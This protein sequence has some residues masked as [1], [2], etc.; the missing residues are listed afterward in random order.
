MAVDKRIQHQHLQVLFLEHLQIGGLR[1]LVVGVE[2]FLVVGFF[3]TFQIVGKRGVVLATRN[4]EDHAVLHLFVELVVAHHA[5]LDEG[6]DIFPNR[7][8]GFHV[9]GKLADFSGDPAGEHLADLA[10][11]RLVLQIAAGNVQRQIRRI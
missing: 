6:M 5:V 7:H 11:L 2:H 3:R 4:L 8:E 1:R 9:L 10:H